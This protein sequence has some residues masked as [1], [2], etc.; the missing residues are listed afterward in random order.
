VATAANGNERRDEIIATGARLFARNGIQATTMRDIGEACGILGGSL[1]YHFQSK[2]DL[3]EIILRRGGDDL[4]RLYD[5]ALRTTD[6]PRELLER[7]IRT[8]VQHA[9][10]H[11][12]G[13]AIFLNSYHY[14]KADPRFD[15]ISEWQHCHYQMWLSV[16]SAGMAAGVFRADLRPRVFVLLLLETV[17]SPARWW[18]LHSG[19]TAA[20]VADEMCALLLSGC[21][22]SV[23]PGKGRPQRAPVRA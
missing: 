1:Y 6:E 3:V 16:I 12:A 10:A 22:R 23:K 13:T 11:P 8:S 9:N 14:L 4:Q 20:D 18:P 19:E 21:L 17:W 15:F 7:L 2:D 5:E